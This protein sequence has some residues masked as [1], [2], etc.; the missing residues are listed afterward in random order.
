M[1]ITQGG[2]R[3]AAAGRGE[4]QIDAAQQNRGRVFESDCAQAITRFYPVRR[5]RIETKGFAAV[6]VI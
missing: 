3:R 2:H 6:G 5:R 4:N 1:N